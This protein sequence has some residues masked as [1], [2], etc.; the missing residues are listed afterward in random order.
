MDIT[1]ETMENIL[2]PKIRVTGAPIVQTD[3]PEDA[4][5]VRVTDGN[6]AFAD[7]LS[8]RRQF[9]ILLCSMEWDECPEGAVPPPF[10]PTYTAFTDIAAAMS[11]EEG[12]HEGA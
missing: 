6:G 5:I 9:R 2:R 8:Q 12:E 4:E 3:L 1:Y 10:T 11:A 7:P